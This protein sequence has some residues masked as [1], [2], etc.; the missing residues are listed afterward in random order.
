MKG[1][2]TNLGLRADCSSCFA[3]CC[4]VPAFA[5]SSDFAIDKPAH[6]ACPNLQGDLRCSIHARTASEDC[7]NARRSGF[8]GLKPQARM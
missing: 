1:S 5:A 6:R 3:L 7:S 2:R 4:V 8:C